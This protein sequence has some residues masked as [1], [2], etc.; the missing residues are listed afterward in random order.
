MVDPTIIDVNLLHGSI[1]CIDQFV[2]S[3]N[4]LTTNTIVDTWLHE[5]AWILFLVK[6]CIK[7]MEQ[8]FGIEQALGNYFVSCSNMLVLGLNLYKGRFPPKVQDNQS[9]HQI[10][11]PYRAVCNY[12][13]FS[14][15][16]CKCHYISVSLFLCTTIHWHVIAHIY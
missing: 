15:F 7:Y 2:V 12:S 16:T 3:V 9:S 4:S 6:E 5:Y 13:A 14:L 1:H 8:V 10:L 11:N